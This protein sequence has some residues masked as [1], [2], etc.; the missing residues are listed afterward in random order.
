VYSYKNISSRKKNSGWANIFTI[1]DPLTGSTVSFTIFDACKLIYEPGCPVVVY[2]AITKTYQGKT[3]IS[4]RNY[5]FYYFGKEI[6]YDKFCRFIPQVDNMKRWQEEG[7][8][9]S[10]ILELK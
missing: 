3:T 1:I 9:V 2:N 8:T 5:T 4:V 6:V 10:D 7:N